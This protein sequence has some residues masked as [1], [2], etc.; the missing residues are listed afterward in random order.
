MARV[1]EVVETDL[2]KRGNGVDIPIRIVTQYWSKDGE[3]LAEYDP[4][5]DHIRI[6]KKLREKVAELEAK[7]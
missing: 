1:I 4:N 5:P 2:T 7:Q 6:I 3:L